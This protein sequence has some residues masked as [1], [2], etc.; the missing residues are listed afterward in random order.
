MSTKR[1]FTVAFKLEVISY[2]EGTSNRKASLYYNIHRR[3]VQEWRKQKKELKNIRDNRDLNIE[4]VRVLAGRGRKVTH[5]ILEKEL[6]EYVKK[7]R[8]EKGTLTTAMI[9][10][11]GK[12]LGEAMDVRDMKFSRG[13]AE[14]FK[15]RNN[16]VKRA[17]TQIAQK[18]P[19]D[20]P[21]II[22]NFLKM[23]REKTYSIEKKIFCLL[24]K[25]QCG[26]ICHKIQQLISKV[27]VK[28]QLGP[29][30]MKNYDLQ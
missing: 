10:K 5:P 30:A 4:K 18:L 1:S 19:E 9:I 28:Y 29:Q 24:M 8:E 27:L 25:R 7:R 2:A 12:G 3:R 23:S 14:R 22:K 6:L 17:R 21:V 11:E 15:Q 20:M 13:W 16:L 26:S